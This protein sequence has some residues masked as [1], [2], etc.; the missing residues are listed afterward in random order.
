[1]LYLNSF[2][3]TCVRCF[4]DTAF[5]H[6]YAPDVFLTQSA[7]SMLKPFHALRLATTNSLY[8]KES[9]SPVCLSLRITE[10]LSPN[11][12]RHLSLASP[13]NPI[14]I[15]ARVDDEWRDGGFGASVEVIHIMPKLPVQK[16]V[17]RRLRPGA[18]KRK[19]V[20]Y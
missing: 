10:P 12:I 17:W 2:F 3:P 8:V 13:W 19:K 6:L 20:F 14:A 5:V 7:T 16:N 1:M 9:A 18:Q 11:Q 4:P 15:E